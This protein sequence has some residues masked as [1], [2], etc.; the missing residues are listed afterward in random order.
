MSVTLLYCTHSD[1]NS[2]AKLAEALI[3]ARLAACVNIYDFV[4][5]V[6]EWEGKVASDAEVVFIVKT[7]QALA[8]K[9]RQFIVERHSYDCPCVLELPVS[10]GHPAFLDFIKNQTS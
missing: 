10:G 2:A 3:E 1:R 9:A 8:E 5:S 4:T 7:R 6:Y